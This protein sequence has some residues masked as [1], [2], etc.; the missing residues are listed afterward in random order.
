MLATVV[1]V[2]L[3]GAHDASAVDAP[4]APPTTVPAPPPLPADLFPSTGATASKSAALAK[5][6]RIVPSGSLVGLRYHVVAPGDTVAS[7]ARTYGVPASLVRTSNG[8]MSNRVYVGAR[9]LLEHPNPRFLR[10]WVSRTST[11]VAPT[12]PTTTRSALAATTTT[13]RTYR[14]AAGDTLSGI[15]AAQRVALSALLT[16]NRL[17]LTSLILPGQLLQVPAA[18]T[19]G[20]TTTVPRP[21]TTTVPATGGTVY[22][23]GTV[24]PK[25]SCP[26]VGAKFMND[27][28]FPRGTRRFHEGTDLFAPQ[29][30]RIVAPAN[31]TVKFGSNTLGGTTFNL[32]TDD[33]WVVYGAHLFTHARTEGRVKAGTVIATVGNTGDALGGPMHLHMSIRPVRGRMMNPYPLLRAACG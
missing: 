32:T 26:V 28:G 6:V 11:T 29:G 5:I 14:V 4:A 23:Y 17:T 3:V 8:I 15:A 27:W 10:R 22:E 19:T 20:P 25:L 12:A 7:I 1:T 31:G 2:S 30:T 9:V 13:A 18:A 33:G 21:P 24:L 16:L